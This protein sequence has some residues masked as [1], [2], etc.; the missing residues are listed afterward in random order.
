MGPRRIGRRKRDS[1]EAFT[2]AA[3]CKRCESE[4]VYTIGDV[5]RFDGEPAKRNLKS[6]RAA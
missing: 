3:R 5:M 2:F 4:T 1:T 6:A